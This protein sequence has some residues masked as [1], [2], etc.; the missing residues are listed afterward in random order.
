MC[1]CI[2]SFW[3]APAAKISHTTYPLPFLSRDLILLLFFNHIPF[4]I[5]FPA[6]N[7]QCYIQCF[8][9]MFKIKSRPFPPLRRTES[10]NKDLGKDLLNIERHGGERRAFTKIPLFLLSSSACSLQLSML[11]SYSHGAVLSTVIIYIMPALFLPTCAH[12]K[13][14]ILSLASCNVDISNLSE[15]TERRHFLAYTAFPF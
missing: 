15:Q 4:A 9:H 10:T 2:L 5:H 8:H 6:A 1:K 7:S 14:N 13:E 3:P 12:I 11:G